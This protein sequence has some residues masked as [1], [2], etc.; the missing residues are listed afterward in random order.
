MTTKNIDVFTPTLQER[1]E[2]VRKIQERMVLR[3]QRLHE[4]SWREEDDS[5]D[6]IVLSTAEHHEISES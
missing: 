6:V 2:R 5:L 3:N 4:G 1:M